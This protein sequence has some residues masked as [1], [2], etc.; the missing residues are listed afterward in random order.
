M[1]HVLDRL[2]SDGLHGV[3][4]LYLSFPSC[5]SNLPLEGSLEGVGS[6]DRL[7]SI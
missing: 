6:F 4:E 5:A 7:I 3:L 1:Q 2:R